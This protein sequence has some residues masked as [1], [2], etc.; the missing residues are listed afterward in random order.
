MRF[1]RVLIFLVFFALAQGAI[2]LAQEDPAISIWEAAAKGDLDAVEA[3]IDVGTDLDSLSEAGEAPLHYAVTK[4]QTEVVVILLDAGV[5][6]D[7]ENSLEET[8]LD[9]AIAGRKEDIIDL[10]LEAGA[11]LDTPTESIHLLTFLGDLLGVKLHIYSGTNIDQEDEYGNYPLLLAVELGHTEIVDLLIEHEVELETEDQDGFTALIISAEKNYPEILQLLLDSGSDVAAEDKAKRTALDWS[12]IMKSTE[13]EDILRENDV[14]SGA[15]KS[16]I[17]AIQTSN[18]DSVK[19]LLK[20]GADV[21]EPA[22]TSKTPMHYASH[23]RDIEILKLLIE[24]DGDLEAKT[25]LGV[26]PLGYAVGLNQPE[27]CRVLLQ[28]GSDVDTIDSFQRTNLNLAV[29]LQL[30]EVVGILLEFDANPNTLDQWHYSSLD[31]AEE[32]GSEAIAELVREAGGINGPKISI[33][34]AAGSRDNA[35][36]S[37]HLFFG[38]D[39]NLLDENSE[40]PMDVAANNN[41]FETIA[42]L[43]KKTRLDFIYDDDGNDLIRII[44]PYGMGDLTPQLEFALEVS[45]NFENWK[46]LESIDTD[47]GVGEIEFNPQEGVESRFYRVIINEIED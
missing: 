4:N 12:I 13:A 22:Y 23:S 27:N 17:A 16:F 19:S 44:G 5:E 41:A 14:P 18:I 1:N 32:F 38:T 11:G 37:L 45:D 29:G 47:D 35:K 24:N 2:L 33:H 6:T 40:T 36:L 42:F 20:Q 30:Q 15:G 21:N 7:I 25:E 43:Q 39:I 46:I 3:H 9:I 10:L 28:A 26:T 34:D 31:V 8:A